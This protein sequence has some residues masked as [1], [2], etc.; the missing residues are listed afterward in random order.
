MKQPQPHRRGDFPTALTIPT[1][2]QFKRHGGLPDAL[3]GMRRA[4][5]RHSLVIS[6][7]ACLLLAGPALAANVVQVRVGNHP[8]F[9]RVVFE[10]DAPSGYRIV[11]QADGG[12]QELIVTLAASSTPRSIRSGS[13]EVSHVAVQQGVRQ[14][15]A[16]IRLRSAN[17]G[18]KELILNDPPR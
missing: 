13:P 5:L 12:A 9:T 10:L 18:V 15:E 7:L 2:S 11:K 4:S 3:A 17:A 6:A 14:T 16:H 1:R 8:T